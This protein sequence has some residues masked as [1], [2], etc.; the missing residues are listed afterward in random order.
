MN[1]PLMFLLDREDGVSVQE[2]H[3]MVKGD[4]NVLGEFVYMCQ[5]HED[6]R[7]IE[8]LEKKGIVRWRI[9]KSYN[10]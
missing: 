10:Q 5:E 3:A 8:P 4:M 7:V 6:K 1:N 2:L 9:K